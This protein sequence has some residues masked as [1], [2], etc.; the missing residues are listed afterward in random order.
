MEIWGF[1]LGVWVAV[2]AQAFT[3]WTTSKAQ[4]PHQQD[5]DETK[6]KSQCSE[7]WASGVHRY[8]AELNDLPDCC[9]IDSLSIWA[10]LNV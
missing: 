7:D 2:L 8:F 6:P 4:F 1:G 9:D 3:G 5:E 10:I